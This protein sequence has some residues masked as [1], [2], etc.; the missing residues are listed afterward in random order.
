MNADTAMYRAK[1]AG[2]GG[3]QF[4]DRSMNARAL[5]R[6]MMETMLRRALERD[7]FVLH[8]QPRDRSRHRRA[9]SAPK[10]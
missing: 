1:E 4:Y 9:S 2:R 8:Y 5:D 7:E 6:L 10:R 3:F